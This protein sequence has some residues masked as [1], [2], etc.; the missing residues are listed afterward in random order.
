M[1]EREELALLFESNR[2]YLRAVAYRM[3]GSRSEAEDAVQEA[4]L[5]LDRAK[6]GEIEELKPWLTV[7]VSR[8]CLDLLRRRRAQSV[9]YAGTWLPEPEVEFDLAES[10]EQSAMV[11]DSVGIALLVVL[12]TL[13]PAERLSFVLHDVFAVP[14]EEIAH[15]MGKTA[16][17]VRQ[18]AS[19][20]RRRVRGASRDPDTDRAVQRRVVEAFLKASRAGDFEGLLAVLDPDVVLRTDGGGTGPL[21]R[22]PVRGAKQVAAVLKERGPL[23]APHGRPALVNGAIGILVGSAQRPI[24]VAGITVAGGRIIE[25]DLIGDPRKLNAVEP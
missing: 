6:A 2:A 11:A 12:E 10:P 21:A 9:A 15:I 13:T 3:L 23:F 1:T 19:R 25:I 7:V 17:S 16:A 22:A 24:A 14:F 20:A 8:I 4:W 5:R 18:L